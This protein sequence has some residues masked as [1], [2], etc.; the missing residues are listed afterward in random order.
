MAVYR[1][2]CGIGKLGDVMLIQYRNLVKKYNQSDLGIFDYCIFALLTVFCFLTFSQADLST[3]IFLGRHIFDGHILDFYDYAYTVDGSCPNYMPSTYIVLGIWGIPLKL[4]GFSPSSISVPF[5]VLMWYKLGLAMFYMTSGFL[6]YKIGL[7]LDFDKIKAKLCAVLFL[8]SPIG[9][10]SQFIFGQYDI[11][12]V[13]FVLLGIYFFFKN[14]L[15]K[16]SLIFGFAITFKYF[17]LP[18]FLILLLLKIK[19]FH[20]LFFYVLLTSI[21]TALILVI[22]GRS[23]AFQVGVLNFGATGYVMLSSIGIASMLGIDLKLIPFIFIL[24]AAIAYFK[25]C[26]TR[27]DLISWTFFLCVIVVFLFFGLSIF[28]PQWLLFSVPFLVFSTCINKNYKIFLFLD[29]LLMLFFVMFTVNIWINHVDAAMFRSGIFKKIISQK[30]NQDIMM[31][32]IFILKDRSIL[33]TFFSGLLMVNVLFKHPKYCFKNILQNIND[34]LGLIRTRFIVGL[35]IFIIP[36]FICFFVALNSPILLNSTPFTDIK[37]IQPIIQGTTVSQ[38]INVSGST[39]KKVSVFIGTYVRI[40]TSTIDFSM[41]DIKTQETLFIKTLETR[42]MK[43]NSWHVI[44]V[45]NIPVNQDNLYEFRFTSSD[46]AVDN[47]V[48]IYSTEASVSEI[49]YGMV[50]GEKQNFNFCIKILGEK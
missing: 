41:I 3:T 6:M 25:N 13:F 15:L 37:A 19:Q 2:L 16:F 17:A 38:V 9:F 26:E 42:K 28:H 14:D 50:N 23:E 20:K 46:S 39:V 44:D 10:F 7:L 27:Q 29:V 45:P 5:K 31:R 32:D 34:S 36:A 48:V 8:T 22:Y 1:F 47:C 12:T 40:N 35:S 24:L 18:V 30:I 4:L 11:L 33:Y 49:C 43:D 21:P